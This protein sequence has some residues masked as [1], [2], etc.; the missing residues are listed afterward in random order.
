MNRPL[1][2]G[3][4][5]ASGA[6]GGD[7]PTHCVAAPGCTRVATVRSRSS[8]PGRPACAPSER[9]R[10]RRDGGTPG[11]GGR[12]TRPSA[13]TAPAWAVCFAPDPRVTPPA[14]CGS[15][16]AYGRKVDGVFSWHIGQSFSALVPIL[17]SLT[18]FPDRGVDDLEPFR[19]VCNQRG[20]WRTALFRAIAHRHIFPFRALRCAEP[21]GGLRQESGQ[22]L[23][24]GSSDRWTRQTR[25]VDTLPPSQYVSPRVPPRLSFPNV[26]RWAGLGVFVSQQWTAFTPR[27][28]QVVCGG[29]LDHPLCEPDDLRRARF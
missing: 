2:D 21:G 26:K 1:T 23:G 9:H 17:K 7:S 19:T 25:G 27:D 24:P 16:D 18:D 11:G 10:P 13:T 22:R 28:R 20:K 4:R 5:M 15:D 3:G 8:A 6:G 14:S 29:L 12:R